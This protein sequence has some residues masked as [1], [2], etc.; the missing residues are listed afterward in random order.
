LHSTIFV[1]DE[2]LPLGVLK[3]QC[4]APELKAESDTRDPKRVPVEEKPQ[5]YTW[6]LG[7]RDCEDM[8]SRMPDTQ[9]IQVMDREADIFELFDEWR[10]GPRH[11]VLLVRAEHNRVTVGGG[12]L[13]DAVKASEAKLALELHV[14]R[15]SARPKKSKQQA[16]PAR[17]GRKVELTVRYQRL[18][19]RPP[20]QHRGK[21]PIAMSI[22]HLLEEN[23]PEGVKAI[24][25]F[26]LTTMEVR[27]PEQAE[28]LSRC[29]ALRW[30]IEDWH[31][32]LKSGCRV[33][34]LRNETAE[35]IK[36]AVAIYDSSGFSVGRIKR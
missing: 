34:D 11:T 31:R 28:F 14:D 33:E 13:F 15:Q 8:A 18:D 4:W 5:T 26:L 7:M 21:A 29:Y 25:W 23:P 32:V 35:R 12:R 16:R 24:E 2:G 17:P 19:L 3:A 22:I 10:S 30:R 9:I 6:I 36:R 27:T 20:D 1:T